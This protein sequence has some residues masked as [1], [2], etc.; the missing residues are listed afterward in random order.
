MSEPAGDVVEALH[1]I[2]DD[3]DYPMLIVTAAAG[4]ARAGCLVGF[5]TQCSI[6]PPRIAVWISEANHTYDVAR[7]AEGLVVHVPS[8]GQ[9]DL[10]ARFGSRTGDEED[11]FAGTAW[12]PGPFGCPVLDEVDRWFAGRVTQRSDTG[13]HLLIVLDVV[14]AEVRGRDWP[15]QLGFQKVKDLEPG[16]E[17]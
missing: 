8:A 13:D 6:H 14:A 12:H 3:L 5:A 2:V 9:R 15:G 1:E 17:P 11:T 4:E 7:V 10:A 16:H